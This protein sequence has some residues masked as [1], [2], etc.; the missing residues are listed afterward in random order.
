MSEREWPSIRAKLD[1][2]SLMDGPS[3]DDSESDSDDDEEDGEDDDDLD[4]VMKDY[5]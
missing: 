4:S 2:L 1:E 3:L 5:M